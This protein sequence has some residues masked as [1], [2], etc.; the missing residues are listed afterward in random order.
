MENTL[1]FIQKCSN[2]LKGSLFPK[3]W[4]CLAVL[5]NI[6]FVFTCL[7]LF[8]TILPASTYAAEC[9]L[10][11]PDKPIPNNAKSINFAVDISGVKDEITKSKPLSGRLRFIFPGTTCGGPFSGYVD[12][13]PS[14]INSFIDIPTV[15]KWQKDYESVW[16]QCGNQLLWEGPHN[17]NI[18]YTYNVA[19]NE[20]NDIMC[21]Q[22]LIYNVL[23]N[24]LN[25]TSCEIEVK[26][27]GIGDPSSTWDVFLNKFNDPGD[28]YW[29]LELT[30]STKD[31]GTL[32]TDLASKTRGY[33]L[34]YQLTTTAI[35]NLSPGEYKVGMYNSAQYNPT[36]NLICEA[37]IKV[38]E[39]G[40]KTDPP[41]PECKQCTLADCNA[42]PQ[43]GIICRGCPI[44]KNQQSPGRAIPNLKPLCDQLP[45]SS[46]TNPTNYRTPCDEC[47]NN[48]DKTK[49]G[50]WTAIGCIP[51]DVNGF[52]ERYIFK[53]GPGMAGGIAFLYFLYGCF[54]ILTSSGDPEKV[55]QGKEIIVAAISG[56]LLIIFSVF[57]LKIVAQDII[58]IPGFGK[59]PSVL[60]TPNVPPQ[61]LPGTFPVREPECKPGNCT[62][63]CKTCPGC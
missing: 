22:D 35:N 62:G 5:L 50:M 17:F 12:I 57:L 7:F 43:H 53:Y 20:Q 28:A 45:S 38:N 52:L 60:S 4:K 1:Y 15:A 9:K 19:N 2:V 41:P 58:G 31:L 25:K 30:S 49:Q 14:P 6:F 18:V 10:L 63:I 37:I 51:T 39:K 54:L 29:H 11:Y 27:N 42:A 40:V 32:W 61:C 21:G 48:T 56:L 44:C 24:P 46:Q 26:T 3:R 36:E 16:G 59:S 34:P 23:P 55:T 13:P 47:V 33:K 8:L